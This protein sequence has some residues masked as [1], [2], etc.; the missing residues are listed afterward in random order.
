[1]PQHDAELEPELF[2][3]DERDGEETAAAA[4]HE[5][6]RRLGQRR[7]HVR[8]LLVRGRGEQ[9]QKG[10]IAGAARRRPVRTE[11]RRRD[12]DRT[13]PDRTR[14]FLSVVLRWPELRSHAANNLDLLSS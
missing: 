14:A 5:R 7:Q 9:Q 10:K 2:G 4:V 12:R 13:G 1:M 3:G 11:E 6:R 8:A